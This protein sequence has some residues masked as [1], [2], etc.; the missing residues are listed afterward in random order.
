MKDSKT[1][2]KN[3]PYLIAVLTTLI[4]CLIWY[5][6]LIK[7]DT[8][9]EDNF[10]FLLTPGDDFS[11]KISQGLNKKIHGD[12]NLDNPDSDL[13]TKWNSDIMLL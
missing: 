10:D 4:L 7:Q 5:W 2:N 3:L 6:V 8:T 9:V 12:A 13:S 11:D 1:A